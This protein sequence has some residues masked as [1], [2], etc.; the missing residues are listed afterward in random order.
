MKQN[1]DLKNKNKKD[2]NII[3]IIE[4]PDGGGAELL[5]RM[6]VS[7]MIKSGLNVSIIYIHNPLRARLKH[8]EYCLNLSHARDLRGIW[9]LRRKLKSLKKKKKKNIVHAHTTWPLYFSAIATIGFKTINFYTEHNTYNGRR[10]FKFLK[11]LETYIY[12]KFHK[13]ICISKGTKKNLIKWLSITSDD[14]K[15]VIVKNGSR[16]FNTIIR[17]K[18]NPKKLRLVSIGLLN[19]KKGFDIAIKTI[20]LLKDQ[21]DHYTIIGDG[22]Q[23]KKLLDLARKLGV[24]DKIFITGYKKNF[25]SYLSNSDIGLVPSRWE[26]FGLVSVEMLSTGLPLVCSNVPGLREVIGKCRAVQLVKPENPKAL[27]RGILKVT[28]Q[29]ENIKSKEITL[30]ARKHSEKFDMNLFCTKYLDLYLDAA[31]K[32]R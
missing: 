15:I 25:K 14:K 29:L 5:I 19:K 27:A 18:I 30:Q 21:I 11:L 9:S 24:M 23:K 8:Y 20:F 3:H 22:N 31:S 13:I 32:S 12:S 4:R 7:L 1:L 6:L 17:K 16:L 2:L 28:K 10:K 26:G